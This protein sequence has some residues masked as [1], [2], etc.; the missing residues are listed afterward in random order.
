MPTQHE[1]TRLVDH[2]R[3]E[4][5]DI[6][7]AHGV[8]ANVPVESDQAPANTNLDEVAKQF[9]PALVGTQSVAQLRRLQRCLDCAALG[10]LGDLT[11]ADSSDVSEQI[12]KGQAIGAEVT[13][14]LGEAWQ[15]D[16][17]L[18]VEVDSLRQ[19]VAEG[20]EMAG[21]HAAE[22]EAVLLEKL[23]LLVLIALLLEAAKLCLLRVIW[24]LDLSRDLL[25]TAYIALAGAST[26]LEAAARNAIANG[27]IIPV[28][29]APNLD[30][31]LAVDPADLAALQAA[32][33]AYRAQIPALN[34]AVGASN[35]ALADARTLLPRCLALQELARRLAARFLEVE[36]KLEP[37][38]VEA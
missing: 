32:L 23:L 34:G 27:A 35:Q 10:N 5:D 33:A 30:G 20:D 38:G 12:Q 29:T 25:A 28:G 6:V 19:R 21:R 2:M 26:D 31:R 4:L 9:A 36:R 11:A 37:P 15:I 24:L 7:R 16:L 3:T 22:Q 1:M 14:L 8:A 18:R 13:R 17:E